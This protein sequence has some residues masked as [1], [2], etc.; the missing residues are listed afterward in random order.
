ME[1]ERVKDAGG[2]SEQRGEKKGKTKRKGTVIR[3]NRDSFTE[4]Q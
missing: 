2:S 4:Q 1:A 3:R